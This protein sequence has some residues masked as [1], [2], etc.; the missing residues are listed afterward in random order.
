MDLKKDP[1]LAA[2]IPRQGVQGWP[3]SSTKTSTGIREPSLVLIALVYRYVSR[4]WIGLDNDPW[5]ILV[6]MKPEEES[7]RRVHAVCDYQK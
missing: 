7:M 5:F 1:D 3:P 4:S 2:A 6:P